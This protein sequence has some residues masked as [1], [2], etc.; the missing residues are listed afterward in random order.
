MD[1]GA[2]AT[3]RSG[4]RGGAGKVGADIRDASADGAEPESSGAA[5]ASGCKPEAERCDD[6]D[7][8]CDMRIDEQLSEA[9]GSDQGECKAGERRCEAGRWSTCIDEVAPQSELCD[10]LDND[11]NGMRDDATVCELHWTRV[12]VAP[13]PSEREQSAYAYDSDRRLFVIHGGFRDSMGTADTWAFDVASDAWRQ[14]SDTGPSP[15]RDHA[16][17]YDATRKRLVMYGGFTGDAGLYDTW[18]FDGQTW[19]ERPTQHSPGDR[20]LHAMVY[21]SARQRVVLFGGFSNGEVS[22]QTWEYD[23][24][25]WQERVISGPSA[26]RSPAATYDTEHKRVLLFGGTPQW[27]T[28]DETTPGFN[29]LW[30]YD[31][32]SWQQLTAADP[33]RPRWFASLVWHPVRKLAFLYGGV[34]M[35]TYLSD[36]HELDG[37]RWIART[38]AFGMPEVSHGASIIYDPVGDRLLS[39]GGTTLANEHTDAVWQLN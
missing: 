35:Q 4:V 27:G 22:G 25:D 20:S 29:D 24:V 17:V 28:G 38:S 6:L 7:N 37:E 30:A 39:F 26:R 8:D 19:Q 2:D 14:L 16:M 11:C 15:R 31:G 36:T 18:E 32:N 23:G 9:C 10:G 21:D 1:A 13:G 5:N 12:S 3:P 33:P 34:Q